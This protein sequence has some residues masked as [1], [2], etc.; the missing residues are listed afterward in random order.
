MLGVEVVDMGI[1]T[2]FC[3][4]VSP[5]QW[6]QAGAIATDLRPC[7]KHFTINTP[8]ESE[9][10]ASNLKLGSTCFASNVPKADSTVAGAACKLKFAS[11]IEKDLL[12]GVCMPSELNL[13]LW[14]R[15]LRVPYTDRAV[16]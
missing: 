2:S 14:S 4:Q 1:K 15:Y 12:K 7:Y 13:A 11:R 9:D 6:V 5:N 3:N 8:G 16:G 10:F